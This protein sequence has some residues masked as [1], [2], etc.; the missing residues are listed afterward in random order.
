MKTVMEKTDVSEVV[1]R[2]DAVLDRAVKFLNDNGVEYS[3]SDWVTI[4]KYCDRFNIKDTRIVSNWIA[5]GIIPS[6]NIRVIEELN[7]L[8]L[9]KAIP[10]ME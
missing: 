4:K 7:G 3:L 2:A 8:K 5:R 6:E 1:E 9:I 10:Y